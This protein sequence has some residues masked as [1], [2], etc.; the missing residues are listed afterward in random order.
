MTIKEQAIKEIQDA[1]EEAVHEALEFLRFLAA[2]ARARQYPTAVASETVL[3]RDWTTPEE[4]SAWE[5]L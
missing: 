5:S 3:A 2:R 1:P 4:E